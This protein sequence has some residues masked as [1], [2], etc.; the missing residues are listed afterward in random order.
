MKYFIFNNDNNL[1]K[2]AGSESDKNSL[3]ANLDNYNVVEVTDDQF[4]KVRLSKAD[5]NYDGS[6]VTLQNRE[7]GGETEI[8]Y[9]TIIKDLINTCDIFL[10]ANESHTM[11]NEI[12]DYRNYLAAFDTSTIS[13]P[14]NMT[15]EE[16]CNTNSI[17]FFHSLQI[18]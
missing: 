14:S 7:T 11:Y 8:H 10:L 4:N 3:N 12:R 15:W 1:W 5:A 6:T 17:T 18:P 13:F 16:Y 9:K 2:I